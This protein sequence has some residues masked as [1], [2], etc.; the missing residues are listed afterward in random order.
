MCQSLYPGGKTP[1][2]FHRRRSKI[3]H[4][5]LGLKAIAPNIFFITLEAHDTSSFLSDTSLVERK[6]FIRCFPALIV[7]S[8]LALLSI[9][10]SVYRAYVS[11]LLHAP[12]GQLL[13]N[14]SPTQHHQL[15]TTPSV[16]ASI[17]FS[18]ISHALK[19]TCDS[20]TCSHGNTPTCCGLFLNSAG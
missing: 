9:F 19:P 18:M 17:I 14:R 1:Q 13:F 10:L 16:L 2:T 11:S 15:F 3:C 5:R 6:H 4:L 7:T 12:T 8:K 20:C